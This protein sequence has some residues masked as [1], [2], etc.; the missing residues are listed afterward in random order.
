MTSPAERLSL[1]PRSLAVEPRSMMTS[2]SG[3]GAVE[4]A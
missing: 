2:A 1:G 4:G 3:T